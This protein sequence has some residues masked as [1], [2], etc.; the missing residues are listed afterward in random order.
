MDGWHSAGAVEF[1]LFF[2]GF[3]GGG[4]GFGLSLDCSWVW[5]G[6]GVLFEGGQNS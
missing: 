6:G 1:R 5:V 4:R 3:F 2:R